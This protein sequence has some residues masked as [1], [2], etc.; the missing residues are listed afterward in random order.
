MLLRDMEKTKYIDLKY[1]GRALVDASDYEY[2]NQFKWKENPSKYTDYCVREDYSSGRRMKLGMHREIMKPKKGVMID[3][4]NH[5][6]LDN[7]RVNLRFCTKSQNAMN[8]PAPSH[9]TSGWKGVSYSKKDGAYEAYI[10]LE[11][12]RRFLGVFKNK[13]DAAMAYNDAAQRL[14]R[15]FAYYNVSE[16]N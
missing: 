12:K 15:E 3:H 8:R 1:G 14:H 7:R 16:F 4:I 13:D 6:G 2:L 5:N 11:Q 10:T 9:N